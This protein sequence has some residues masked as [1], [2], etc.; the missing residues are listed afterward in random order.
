MATRMVG[1]GMVISSILKRT[2]PFLVLVALVGAGNSL[3]Q[4]A[5]GFD[6]SGSLIPVREIRGGGPPRDGIP[7]LNDP[8]RVSA[9][10]ADTWLDED[11]RVIGI[12]LGDESVAYPIRILNWHEIVNDVVGGQAVAI[13]YCPLC[14]TGVVFNATISGKRTIF[15]VSGLLYNSDVLLFDRG[16]MSLFSQ[17]MFKAVTGPLRGTKL[18][19]LPAV[20]TTWGAWKQKH[21]ATQVLSQ[22]LP[23][24][25]D[26][27]S[28][29]YEFYHR[30][31]TTMFRAKGA[32]GSRGSK[33]WAWLIITGHEN[34]L[35]SEET[36]DNL[37]GNEPG[38]YFTKSGTEILYDATA[39]ELRAHE[40]GGEVLT[41]IP[42]YWFA[43]T[44]FHPDARELFPEELMTAEDGNPE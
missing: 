6:L 20:T 37:A 9:G 42:G 10:N 38:T 13:T 8:A 21:P 17:M 40:K 3:A 16:T 23:Y 36:L 27:G 7:A 11:D 29:P 26:Y 44:A 43:L 35:V 30:S 4:V 34:L 2:A 18:H 28:D 12:A 25:R 22:H 5:N 39:R 32:D 41:V 15:G 24:M 1:S 33:T 31:G 19:T 14:G